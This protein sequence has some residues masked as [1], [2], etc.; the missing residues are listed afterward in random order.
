MTCVAVRW[1]DEAL[2]GQSALVVLCKPAGAVWG[3]VFGAIL[4][5]TG[6]A[7]LAREV[8]PLVISCLSRL[9]WSS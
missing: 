7:Y 9:S 5:L 2:A 4:I 3:L 1:S 8:F 6:L